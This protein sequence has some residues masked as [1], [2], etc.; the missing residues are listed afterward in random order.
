M[1]RIC[2]LSELGE[3][4]SAEVKEVTAE[5]AVRRRLYDLGLAP[6]TQVDCVGA[7]P[8][9]DPRAYR[10]RG[11]VLALRGCDADAVR[12]R[13]LEAGATRVALCGNPN[14][15]KSTLFNALTG[16]RQHTGNW[17][18]KTVALASGRCRGRERTYWLTDLPG[19]YSLQ[20]R[21]PEEKLARDALR[22]GDFDAAVVVCDAGCL[23]R[24]LGLVLQVMECCERVL[25]AV[26]LLDE[27]E[28]RGLTVDL[29]LLRERLGVPVIGL[30]AHRRDA[31]RRLLE[32]L[33]ALFDSP[34]PEKPYRVRYPA[35]A[36]SRLCG[37]D[38]CGDGAEELCASALLRAAEEL[39]DGVCRYRVDAARDRPDRALDR[40]LTG[41][42]TA[43]PLLLMLLAFLFWL[44]VAGANVPSERLG[45]LLFSLE[46]PLRALLLRA[47]LP[48]VLTVLLTEGAY[49]VLAWV[50]SVMLPPMAIFFPLFT[51]LEEAGVL[52][53]A[54]YDLDR[55]F[56]RCRACGKQALC[57]MMGMGCNAVGVTGCRIIESRRERLLAML[58]NALIPCNG[59][60]PLLIAL[61]S[62]FFTGALGSLAAALTLTGLLLL[63]VGM[64]LLLTRLLSATLLRGESAPF[65]LEL[66][67]YRVPRFGKVLVRS[68]LD[69]TLRILGRAAA[70]AAPAGALLW[71]L[72]HESADG[73]SLLTQLA[74]A[75]D[76]AGRLL[77]MDGVLLLAFLLALPANEI[78]LPVALMI[79]A[80]GGALT[81]PGSLA[82]IGRT[83]AAQGWSAWT[84][85]AVMLFSI[86][87]FPCGTTLLTLR[88]ESGSWG[89]TLLGALLPT[90]LGVLLCLL[91]H[92]LH[93][94]MG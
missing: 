89:W 21:S 62:L 12:V 16:L 17:P 33:D 49:R 54:A 39:C 18:G 40:L 6:G 76:G 1:K 36:A 26:N 32:A 24:N 75:L 84:A 22:G 23:L 74:A 92:G 44:S 34:P 68:L 2:A 73:Q 67:P 48:E 46:A 13:P 20:A 83:L 85:A 51:L 25:V 7:S 27:A 78:V 50:V 88:R 94:L 70:V 59:R 66:P 53:R 56:Q 43:W 19:A 3:G 35:G 90:A 52:P 82:E 8:A 47:G 93:L 15:G 79:Y 29:A 72:A 38:A 31:K 81:E 86:F 63:S 71:L 80:A 58:T 64:S 55:P 57:M 65:I 45:K 5:G 42:F 69:R 91:L 10:A 11:A 14:V 4:C 28:R 41:R 61:S 37:D 60:W 30:V 9:G 77:E 87:H